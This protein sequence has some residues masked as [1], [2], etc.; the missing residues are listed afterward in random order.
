[1]IVD[2]Y[3]SLLTVC[4]SSRDPAFW[5]RFILSMW[6]EVGVVTWYMIRVERLVMVM[7]YESISLSDVS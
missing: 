3:L 2:L 4:V 6:F 1:M 5:F 7:L